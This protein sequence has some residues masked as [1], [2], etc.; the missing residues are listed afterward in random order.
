MYGLSVGNS[1]IKLVF[2]K[3]FMKVNQELF[4]E[5]SPGLHFADVFL[6]MFQ[7]FFV[8]FLPEY[9]LEF[10]LE[11]S[12]ENIPGFLPEDLSR[13]FHKFSQQ[14]F[15]E[16]SWDFFTRSSW[17]PADILPTAPP[18]VLCGVLPGFSSYTEFLPGFSLECCLILLPKIFRENDRIPVVYTG[19][20][21]RI[22]P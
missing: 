18:G 8:G 16:A 22:V 1:K 6:E 11:V 9:L 15:L 21:L 5:V 7:G 13:C 17:I 12:R 19:F 2:W 20:P 3:V 10:F 4:T 14:F